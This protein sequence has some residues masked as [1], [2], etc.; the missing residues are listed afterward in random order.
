MGPAV[1][2]AAAVRGLGPGS[3]AAGMQQGHAPWRAAWEGC[4]SRRGDAGGHS[5]LPMAAGDKRGPN[6]PAPLLYPRQSPACRGHQARLAE[7]DGDS[8]S[9]Q[10]CA[11]C[12]A[13]SC[14]IANWY[15]LFLSPTPQSPC[16]KMQDSLPGANSLFASCLGHCKTNT[17]LCLAQRLS[18]G[19]GVGSLVPQLSGGCGAPHWQAHPALLPG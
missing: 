2:R 4:P 7:D 6:R 19:P 11:Q 13:D 10:T 14:P 12:Q 18:A 8:F 15:P 9:F 5:G 17:Y 1:L 3:P 16:L